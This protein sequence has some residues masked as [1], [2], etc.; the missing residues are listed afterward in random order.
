MLKNFQNSDPERFKIVGFRGSAAMCGLQRRVLHET[1][2]RR[3][4]KALVALQI[5]FFQSAELSFAPFIFARQQFFR[6]PAARLREFG[7]LK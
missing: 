2:A 1:Q 3:Q 5:G 4:V 6:A 7:Q